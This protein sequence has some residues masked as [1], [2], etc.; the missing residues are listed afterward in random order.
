MRSKELFNDGWQ[1]YYGEAGPI[2][3]TVKK[4]GS[5][6]GLTSVLPG[7]RGD[8]VKLGPAGKFISSL[9]PPTS[10][11]DG[12]SPLWI[13]LG[14]DTKVSV[15]GWRPV[16]LPHDWKTE[17]EY[18]PEKRVFMGGA[19]ENGVGYYRKVFPLAREDE[20]KRIAVEFNGVCRST[21]VWFNGCFLGDH[22]SGYTS[23]NF[24]LTDLANYGDEGDNVLLVRV[25]TT[26]GDEGWW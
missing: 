14:T 22:Y 25:D 21:S 15:A 23:F 6:G 17:L 9:M 2:P 3:K 19:K 10:E 16:D 8:A 18:T 13:L 24:D 5:L 12:D 11:N 26:T 1:F 4:S 7:E 20:G